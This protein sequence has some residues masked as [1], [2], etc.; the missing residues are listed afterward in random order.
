MDVLFFFRKALLKYNIH[1]LMM[2]K[3]AEGAEKE[4]EKGDYV[5]VIRGGQKAEYFVNYPHPSGTWIP[6]LDNANNIS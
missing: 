2:V 1:I 3:R 6:K 5:S 4:M